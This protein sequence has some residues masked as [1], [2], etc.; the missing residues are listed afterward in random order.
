[1]LVFLYPENLLLPSLRGKRTEEFKIEQRSESFETL[2]EILR[3][4]LSLTP[5]TARYEANKYLE[6]LSAVLPTELKAPFEITEQLNE[7]QLRAR[8]EQV[9]KL[10]E[11]YVAPDKK[12]ELFY[13]R[14]VFYF[15]PIQIALQLQK[16][17]QYTAALDWFQTV[18]AYNLPVEKR[19]IYYGLVLEGSIQ[20]SYERVL[21]KWLLGDLNPHGIATKRKDAYT[22]FTLLSM[23]RC[24]LDFADSE[25]T[26]DTG[27]SNSRAR[28][29]YLSALDLLD[30]PE[31][32]TPKDFGFAPNPVIQ[33][34]RL[35]AE[36]NL[37]KLRDN[38]NIAGMQR[39]T[40]VPPPTR[41]INSLPTVGGGG[42]LTLPGARPIRATP[43]RYSVLM[44]RA[45]H[46]VALAQQIE[47]AYFA[48]LERTGAEGY[49]E[50]KARQD[51]DLA[52]AGVELQ[53]L[54]VTEA[55]G[56]VTLATLQQERS[57]FQRDH[58]RDLITEG[59]TWYEDASL[60]SQGVAVLLHTVSAG[61]YTAGAIAG[62]FSLEALVNSGSGS[63]GMLAQASSSLAAAASSTS[64]AFA[65]IA[66]Y[67]RREQEWQFQMNLAERDVAI[68]A[69]QI[70][71]AQDRV[72][73]VN[74]ELNIAHT[75]D[76]NANAAV[77]FLTT[78]RFA[79]AELY[80]W[81][82]GILARV[83]DY[84]L[85]QATATARLAQ[86][87]LAFERQEG[88][89][90]IVQSDYWQ[91]PSEGGAMQNGSSDGQ[92]PDRQGITGSARL[93]QDIYQLDQ[94]AFETDK[95]KL[96]LT[97]TISLA[98]TAPIEFQLFR[99][100]GVLPF[101]TPMEIF[102]RDF[103]GQY[104]RLIKRVRT[105]VV[106]LVPPTQ[107]IRAT[108]ATTGVSRV[109]TSSI[110]VFQTVPVYRDP[111]LV[112]LS[113]PN[114]ATGLFELDQQSDMLLPFE[115]MGVD[116]S[117]ELQ[118]PKAA[119]PFD[120]R[121]IADV[122]FTIEYTALNDFDYR[123]QVI[124][125]LDRTVGADRLFSLRQQYSDQWYDL[126]NPDLTETPMTVSFDTSHEDFP[127]N[128]EDLTIHHIVLYIARSDGESFNQQL[129]T[130]LYFTP[131]SGT[132]NGGAATSTDG[133]FSTRRGNANEWLNKICN[134][135]PE[136]T[137]RLA[138]PNTQEV[139]DLFNNEEI[140]D[141]LLVIT[142]TGTMPEWPA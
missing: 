60:V 101:A 99:E 2:A 98:H 142:Y 97:K 4:Q 12:S 114:N 86:S 67:E 113:S 63:F 16:S 130:N 138:L 73:V 18:Y 40:E 20:S 27:E 59:T 1:M 92:A 84:F 72:G 31:L 29:L 82:S 49:T 93:L 115:A 55:N 88:V 71:S 35:H 28:T 132:E 57:Q 65:T 106:A 47:A 58:Y 13:V 45:K 32:Q 119:N 36:L 24:F 110:G 104:L 109:I 79:T 53:N 129:T 117:W 34:M 94:Y 61:I 43:Y 122:L 133:V 139:K 137:W 140:E 85:Q 103:P 37:F 44:E 62:T 3:G 30:L 14:E 25:F 111:E 23:V 75:Q 91:P 100:T 11:T 118:M 15:V 83:Y 108:L 64:S 7:T 6:R 46:L 50:L 95:R 116:T 126:S 70:T 125:E 89:L 90:S 136:G 33:A 41:M 78:G 66:S 74:Q 54:R 124:R 120:Y 51:L 105:S 21:T 102:D 107:G 81:M 42:Q 56:G 77:N 48:A 76:V 131:Q 135:A 26:N 112:A 69:Q 123:Q 39:Q 17:R 9:K 5:D 68:G 141:I 19:K 52:K 22:R 87:Q 38:R 127:P 10:F 8:A 128:I 134:Q 80:E 121:T 96:Q